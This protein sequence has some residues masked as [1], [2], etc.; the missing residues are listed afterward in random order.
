[1]RRTLQTPCTR[2]R[3]RERRKACCTP[4]AVAV[5]LEFDRVCATCEPSKQNMDTLPTEYMTKV[6]IQVSA[7]SWPSFPT[8]AGDT[9]TYHVLS[10]HHPRST[11]PSCQDPIQARC[12]PWRAVKLSSGWPPQSCVITL[13][14][15][16]L[17]AVFAKQL[18]AIACQNS[19]RY[20]SVHLQQI[21]ERVV[22][23]V[24][25]TVSVCRHICGMRE[26]EH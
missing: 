12:V 19:E 11:C 22:H 26:A 18:L 24:R 17:C 5:L 6:Q 8:K 3:G 2:F 13:Q 10:S 1:M 14:H 23:G 4:C 21:E 15:D 25:R 16:I 9:H 7:L 20:R